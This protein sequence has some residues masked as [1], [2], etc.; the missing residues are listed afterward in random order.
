MDNILD[1]K[2]PKSKT[3]SPAVMSTPQ[4]EDV[5]QGNYLK[6]ILNFA[7][8]PEHY[9]AKYP[10]Y[11]TTLPPSPKN[12]I[13]NDPACVTCNKYPNRPFKRGKCYMLY[14]PQQNSWCT[15]CGDGGSNSNWVR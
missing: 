3:I 5:P 2:Y 12:N 9:K 10:S 11:C 6:R 4:V 13:D 8:A 14:S 15:F 1:T 7:K